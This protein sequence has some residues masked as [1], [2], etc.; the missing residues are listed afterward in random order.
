[1]TIKQYETIETTGINKVPNH[2]KHIY[3]ITEASPVERQ[4]NEVYTIPAYDF[5][6]AGSK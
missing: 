1:M 5:L 2:E 4:E 6:K 3:V